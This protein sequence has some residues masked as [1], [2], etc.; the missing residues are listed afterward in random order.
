M[1]VVWKKH[2]KIYK[3]KRAP[4]GGYDPYASHDDQVLDGVKVLSVPADDRGGLKTDLSEPSVIGTET[5]EAQTDKETSIGIAFG[6]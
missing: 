1:R 3:P 6:G 2:G 4:V 5:G